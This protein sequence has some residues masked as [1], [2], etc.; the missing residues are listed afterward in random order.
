MV[1]RLI[2]IVAALALAGCATTGGTAC[3]GWTPIRP[4]LQD[5]GTMSGELAGQILA[6]NIHG[7]KVC[8]WR[9]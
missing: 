6:H 1:A 9:P 4:N 8:G 7:G 5:L 3:D 2:L